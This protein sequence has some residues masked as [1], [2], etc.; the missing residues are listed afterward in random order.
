MGQEVGGEGDGGGETGRH[1]AVGAPNKS[2]HS[3]AISTLT[4][5]F[6]GLLLLLPTSSSTPT[7]TNTPSTPIPPGQ[8]KKKIGE[9]F[10]VFLEGK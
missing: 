5:T 10:S 9:F 7:P 6:L 2:F 1:F 8:K 4:S 3:H